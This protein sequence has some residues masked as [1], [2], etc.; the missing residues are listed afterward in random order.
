MS[1]ENVEVVRRVVEAFNRRELLLDDLDP[2]VEWVED[3]RFPGAETFHGPAGVERSVKKWWDAWS[4]IS[5]HLVDVVDLGDRVVVAGRTQ[6]R[7]HGSEVNVTAEFG[8]VY[9]FRRGKVVRVQI[10]GSR[11]DA[12]EAAGIGT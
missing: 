4:E 6:A 1:Q 12:L 5:M 9:E 11:A 3:Q 2:E 7:G 8:G 10:L